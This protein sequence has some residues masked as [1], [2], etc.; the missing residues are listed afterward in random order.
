[1]TREVKELLNDTCN[2]G[3]DVRGCRHRRHR[4]R[5]VQ[6]FRVKFTIRQIVVAC[7]PKLQLAHPPCSSL[8]PHEHH[9]GTSIHDVPRHAQRSHL[10]GPPSRHPRRADIGSH[11]SRVGCLAALAAQKNPSTSSL[12]HGLN[13]A[14]PAVA[15]ASKHATAKLQTHRPRP[16]PRC[17]PT[18]RRNH[19]HHQQ[20]LDRTP[21]CRGTR[22]HTTAP[23]GPSQ[24]HAQD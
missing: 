10:L 22:N 1:M 5:S 20:Q 13:E 2:E 4:P 14:F 11:V 3:S 21:T 17:P 24:P 12:I 9:H 23:A 8:P 6:C 15:P 16:P 7:P 18:S 19:G